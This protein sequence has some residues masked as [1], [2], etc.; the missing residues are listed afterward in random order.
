MKRFKLFFSLLGTMVHDGKRVGIKT[1][2]GTA[3]ILTTPKHKINYP[4]LHIS[5]D[6]DNTDIKS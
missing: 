4:D 2:W 5:P 6:V 3:V 1:A